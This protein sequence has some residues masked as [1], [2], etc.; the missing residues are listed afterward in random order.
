MLWAGMSSG[1][2]SD[3]ENQRYDDYLQQR[4]NQESTAATAALAFDRTLITLSGGA[5]ALTVTLVSFLSTPLVC[6]VLL[7]LSWGGFSISLTLSLVAQRVGVHNAYQAIEVLTA[8]YKRENI[9]YPSNAPIDAL[10]WISIT[11]FFGGLATA[12][13][14]VAFNLLP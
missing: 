14:F 4:L 11:L 10:E 9:R 3:Y 5:I 2:D 6:P 12:L 8:G 1:P 7:L 13:M